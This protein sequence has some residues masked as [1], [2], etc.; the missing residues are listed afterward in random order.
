MTAEARLRALCL[1]L[2]EAVEKE[3]WEEPTF[4]IRDKIFA[5]I[6]TDSLTGVDAGPARPGFE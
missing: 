2:P 4:R 1:A 3:T 5:M 6:R